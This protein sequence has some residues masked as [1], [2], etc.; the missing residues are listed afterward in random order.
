M[1]SDG[2]L[3]V[4]SSPPKA[5]TNS[6]DHQCDYKYLVGPTSVR[7]HRAMLMSLLVAVC[8]MLTLFNAPPAVIHGI[9]Q[10]ELHQP[11]PG[12][13]VYIICIMK[14]VLMSGGFSNV[15]GKL[16]WKT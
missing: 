13:F 9:V 12:A 15:D 11:V 6:I 2:N 10:R 8:L 16:A 4:A 7:R 14:I 1:P 3:Y 5:V